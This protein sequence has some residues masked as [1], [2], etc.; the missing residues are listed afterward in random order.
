MLSLFALFL[1]VNIRQWQI[2]GR[3]L[4]LGAMKN[5][6]ELIVEKGGKDGYG[7]SLSTEPGYQFGYKYL[8]DY[9]GASPDTPPL[10]DQKKIFTIVIPPG[11]DGIQAKVEYDGI[12]VLWEGID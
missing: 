7:V 3:P 11:M 4:N 6:V 9:Y 2:R 5:A 12:G 8:F 1:F 10:K